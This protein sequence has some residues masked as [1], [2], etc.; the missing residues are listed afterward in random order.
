MKAIQIVGLLALTLVLPA[1]ANAVEVLVSPA[2]DQVVIDDH[3]YQ[4]DALARP[5]FAERIRSFNESARSNRSPGGIVSGS[6]IIEIAVGVADG[7]RSHGGLCQQ[8]DGR[9]S[10]T[11]LVCDDEMVGHFRVEDTE[12]SGAPIERVIEFAARHCFGG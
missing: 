9:D 10:K 4:V 7:N 1:S 3:P 12:R 2:L 5:S 8:T 11:V 6:A